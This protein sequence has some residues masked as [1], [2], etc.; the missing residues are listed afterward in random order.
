MSKDDGSVLIGMIWMI[1]ISILL[2]WLPV[3]GPIIAGIIGG[4]RT[5]GIGGAILAVFLPCILF[6]ILLFFLGTGLTWIPLIGVIAGM[7]GTIFAIAQ[8]GPLLLGAIIG[9]FWAAVD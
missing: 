9:G 3:A 8:V 2:F 4:K 1:L 5:G 6:G 7:G